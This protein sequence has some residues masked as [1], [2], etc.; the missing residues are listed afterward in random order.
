M[1]SVLFFEYIFFPKLS[2]IQQDRQTEILNKQKQSNRKIFT[3][4]Y[5]VAKEEYLIA[6]RIVRDVFFH[7]TNSRTFSVRDI[8]SS[9]VFYLDKLSMF[10]SIDNNYDPMLEMKISIADKYNDIHLEEQ[11]WKL[12]SYR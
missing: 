1:S 6:K 5:F 3:W 7:T 12:N 2:D 10:A 4:L 8:E 9:N 11:L